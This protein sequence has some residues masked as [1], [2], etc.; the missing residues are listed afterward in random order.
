MGDY[1]GNTTLR[2]AVGSSFCHRQWFC[3]GFV[4]VLSMGKG[5]SGSIAGVLWDVSFRNLRGNLR[6]NLGGRCVVGTYG[7]SLQYG[8][9]GQK[10]KIVL[11]L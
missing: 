8:L 9:C 3:D 1:G 5:S 11:C 2:E 7:I 6:G 4:M 10:G